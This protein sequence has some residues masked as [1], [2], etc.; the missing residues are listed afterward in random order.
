MSRTRRRPASAD[1]LPVP[2]AQRPPAD[3][4][5][6]VVVV[7]SDPGALAAAIACRQLGWEVLVAEPGPRLGGPAASRAGQLWLPAHSGLADDDY[8]TARDYFDRVV[9]DFEPCS[10]AP[11]RHAFLTGAATLADW[12]AQL[13][14]KLRPDAA[15]DYYPQLPGARAGRI[16]V[17]QPSATG[18][19]GQLAELLPE[20]SK[21]ALQTVGELARGRR[22]VHGGAALTAGLLA[23]CQRLQ[24]NIWWDAPVHQLVLTSEE[25]GQP[26]RVAGVIIQR[27]QRPVR[28]L[29]GRGVILA[30]GGFEADGP[31]RREYL[32]RPSRPAWTIGPAR[33]DGVRQLK[34]A[35]ELGLLLAGMGYA[36]WRPGLWSPDGQVW[37]ATAALR[38]P[39]S[40]VIDQTG[41]RF[42]N[43]AAV[44]SDFC[45]A[46]Y[47]RALDLGPETATWLIADAEY[48]GI[49]RA[50]ERSGAVLSARTLPE[51]AWQIKVDAAG[52]LATADRFGQLAAAGVDH[53]FG[54]PSDGLGTIG[55]PPFRAMRVVPADLGTKGGLA[56]DEHARVLT[57]DGPL[58]GLWAIGSAASSVSGAA[59]PAPGVGL[60][61]AMVA[62]RAAA[63]AI[64]SDSWWLLDR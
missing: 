40:I 35:A 47:R 5:T 42:T 63:V 51:L 45:R 28:V 52:L 4:M 62:G 10:S 43:E 16:L 30:Q 21:T 2:V 58:P 14:V 6:D 34:W 15:S 50:A 24:V 57:A 59:D 27:G 38:G 55:R 36:W 12:L 46:W 11:R 53:D 19:I 33:D 61:E 25:T 18:P 3:Q 37:D 60:A 64:S 56:T 54:R 32:P 9:G 1:R 31:A 13:R 26:V 22:L 49:P 20:S 7:G 8:A 48:R 29:A 41:R 23:A 39:H 17:P 44:A